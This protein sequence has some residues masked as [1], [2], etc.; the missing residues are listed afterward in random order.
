MF[1][2]IRLK[3]IFFNSVTKML[4]LS[5]IASLVLPFTWVD[6]F[7]VHVYPKSPSNISPNPSEVICQSIAQCGWRGPKPRTLG[8]GQPWALC[9]DQF[10][11]TIEYTITDHMVFQL[12]FSLNS[13]TFCFKSYSLHYFWICQVITRFAKITSFLSQL[14]HVCQSYFMF[15]KIIQI[16]L[17]FFNGGS[18]NN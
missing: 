18:Q 12:S 17:F 1:W 5:P 14:L 9:L 8:L 3:M 13:L 4:A 11:L 16:T 7:S 6:I 10:L 15:L 2:V